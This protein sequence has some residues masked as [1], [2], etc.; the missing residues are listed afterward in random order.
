MRRNTEVQVQIVRGTATVKQLDAR[1]SDADNVASD[2]SGFFSFSGRVDTQQ[3]AKQLN[4]GIE[5]NVFYM[6]DL[7]SWKEDV[8]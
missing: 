7:F 4:L 6:L 2:F 3:R 5:A 8:Y 1:D